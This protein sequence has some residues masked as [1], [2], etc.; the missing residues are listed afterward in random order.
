[1]FVEYKMDCFVYLG[2]R[3]PKAPASNEV[4]EPLT[5][6]VSCGIFVYSAPRVLLVA[7]FGEK[8]KKK[9]AASQYVP[10]ILYCPNI[11]TLL[12]HTWQNL[13]QPVQKPLVEVKFIHF[14]L[15]CTTRELL[16]TTIYL[17]KNMTFFQ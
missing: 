6:L 5:L 1:M 11:S 7:S 17:F 8:A 15:Q 2:A 10:S 9:M 4:C 3:I 13:C 16:T 12:E 14:S